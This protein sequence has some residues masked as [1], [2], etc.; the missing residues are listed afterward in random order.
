MATPEPDISEIV[1]SL[2]AQAATE[3]THLRALDDERARRAAIAERLERAVAILKEGAGSAKPDDA[4]VEIE[5]RESASRTTAQP[6]PT[7]DAVRDVLRQYAGRALTVQTIMRAI[8]LRGW[9]DPKLGAPVEAVRYAAKSLAEAD[10]H[11]ERVDASSFRWVDKPANPMA[12][13]ALGAGLGAA[14]AAVAKAV[15]G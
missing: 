4:P 10:P 12:S 6:R 2:E 15:S 13:L 9:L 7:K 11:I 8:E 5:L 14:A 1:R 3:R